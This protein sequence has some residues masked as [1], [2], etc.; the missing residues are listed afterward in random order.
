MAVPGHAIGLEIIGRLREQDIQLRLASGAGNPG[1]CIGDEMIRIHDAGF[2]QR[3]KA[4]LDAGRITAGIRHQPRLA[5]VL[6]VY[7]RQAIHGLGD[8]FGTRVLHA[9]PL[10]PQRHVL[11]AEICGQ[12]NDAN[13]G[14]EQA[15]R[16]PHRHAVGGGEEHYIA[17]GERRILG[18]GE[19]QGN[20]PPQAGNM[21]ATAVP[22]SL[23]E[24]MVVRTAWGCAA[25]SRS[26]STPV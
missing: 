17:P 13:A 11:D 26:S 1:L 3:Q 22:A 7:L 8:E 16:P 2:Q 9:V 24:V 4:K 15:P 21:S 18:I 25:R 23:R 10:L 20:T 6:P 12:V 5:D 14:I 19:F